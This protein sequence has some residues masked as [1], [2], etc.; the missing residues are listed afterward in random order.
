MLTVVMSNAREDAV[1]I[2]SVLVFIT[3]WKGVWIEGTVMEEYFRI[4]VRDTAN[5]WSSK[6]SSWYH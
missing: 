2:S 6:F 1:F 5:E 3:W 4:K